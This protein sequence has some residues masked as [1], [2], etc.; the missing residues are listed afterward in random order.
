MMAR[1]TALLLLGLG[2]AL[3]ASAVEI[4]IGGNYGN[5][6]GC[7][8]LATS[9]YEG[10][11][12]VA[13]TPKDVQTY[14]TLCSFVTATTLEN[15]TIVTTVICGHE[16]EETQTLGLMRFTK[17]FEGDRWGIYD[18]DGSSWGEVARCH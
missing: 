10:D 4:A 14:V 8:Y 5:E 1:R 9:N 16:G 17:S 15:G 3:P 13:L 6:A 12:L 18:E 2:M 11:D 7:K